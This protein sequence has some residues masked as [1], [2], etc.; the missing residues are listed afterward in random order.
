MDCAD[1]GYTWRLLRVRVAG[2][3]VYCGVRVAT[4][5]GYPAVAQ[6][7]NNTKGALT[8]Y[9]ILVGFD[10]TSEREL[11]QEEYHT[12]HTLTHPL[13]MK[14]FRWCKLDEINRME[15][16][17]TLVNVRSDLTTEKFFILLWEFLLEINADQGY[18]LGE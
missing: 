1:Q 15:R 6:M 13:M 10:I 7:D 2:G 9:S 16:F 5:G 18:T 4:M 12:I 8:L 11:S 3:K 17:K 14:V